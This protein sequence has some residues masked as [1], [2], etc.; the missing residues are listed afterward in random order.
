MGNGGVIETKV[1]FPDVEPAA[2]LRMAI[3]SAVLAATSG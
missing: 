2:V 1:P 3:L